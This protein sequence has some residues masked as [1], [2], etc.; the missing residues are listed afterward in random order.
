MQIV[1][2]GVMSSNLIPE[3]VISNKWLIESFPEFPVQPQRAQCIHIKLYLHDR[4]VRHA[5]LLLPV[6]E[7]LRHGHGNVPGQ[8]AD[9]E[10]R[11]VHRLSCLKHTKKSEERQLI[12]AQ[13][14]YNANMLSSDGE[15][16]F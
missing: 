4:G 15:K 2:S 11:A 6:A 12:S 14:R 10:L 5:D 9:P 3:F 1:R 8:G 13:L 16:K 7:S